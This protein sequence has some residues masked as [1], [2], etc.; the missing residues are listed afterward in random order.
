[1]DVVT[2]LQ[3]V[4]KK[5]SAEVSVSA[6]VDFCFGLWDDR[7]RIPEWM[8]WIKSVEVQ[9]DDP[10]LS[11]W[12]LETE[13]FGQKFRF[14]WLAK[15]MTPIKNRL[16]HW[17]SVDDKEVAKGRGGNGM[18]LQGFA[19]IKN[20]GEIQFRKTSE[21]DC[22]IRLVISYQLPD[23]LLPL[24]DLLKPTVDGILLEYMQ[25]FQ[26][27]AVAEHQHSLGEQE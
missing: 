18:L 5:N 10:R 16:I 2:P 17:V 1:L 11:V 3:A 14:S 13:Q 25:N 20:K 19:S 24:V 7:P 9:E 27:V 8:R 21:E 12:S 26:T 23:I 4:W 15:N 6:P 22:L